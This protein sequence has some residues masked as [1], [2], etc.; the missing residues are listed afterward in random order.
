MRSASYSGLA[1][2]F[3]ALLYLILYEST[4]GMDHL[5]LH[6]FVRG[7]TGARTL[8]VGTLLVLALGCLPLFLVFLLLSAGTAFQG[9]LHDLLS[10]TFFLNAGCW[11]A[12]GGLLNLE[13]VSSFMRYKVGVRCSR[14]WRGSPTLA[15]RPHTRPLLLSHLRSPLPLLSWFP[16]SDPSPMASRRSQTEYDAFIS[17]RVATESRFAQLLWSHLCKQSLRVFLDQRCLEDGKPWEE[18]FVRGCAHGAPRART[19]TRTRRARTPHALTLC[20][21]SLPATHLHLH[22]YPQPSTN[23]HGHPPTQALPSQRLR[24]TLQP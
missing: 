24:P 23:T 9:Q 4:L 2:S 17:Y 14:C 12:I 16:L 15:A 3:N 11:V 20:R 7:Q 10:L 8:L 5:T 21:L 22:I 18:G 13:F 19:H 6:K 1:L